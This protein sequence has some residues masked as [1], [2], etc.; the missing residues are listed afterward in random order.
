[1]IPEIDMPG[2]AFSWT[3]VPDIVSCAGKQPWELYCAEPPCGQLDPTQDETYEVVRTLLEEVTRLFP[4]RAVHIGGDE[5]R[6]GGGGA[7]KEEASQM[8]VGQLPMLGRRRGAEAEDASARL[9]GFLGP[10]AVL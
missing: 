4:D 5:V 2:H 7:R 6:G 10:V 1:M 9:R 3:G 8:P